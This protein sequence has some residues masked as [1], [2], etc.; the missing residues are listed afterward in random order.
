MLYEEQ[1]LKPDTRQ[2][3][4]DLG[5]LLGRDFF[6]VGGT[7]LAIQ[8]GHRLSID[9]DFFTRETFEPDA[10]LETLRDGLGSR[11]LLVTGRAQNTLNLVIDAVKVDLIRYPYTLLAQPREMEGYHLLD[12]PDIAAMKL[13]AVTNRGSK[14]D[15]FDIV[16]L[17]RDHSLEQLL[18]FYTEKFPD[19]DPFFVIRSLGFFEDADEEPDPRMLLPLS[20]QEVK[21]EIGKQL[22]KTC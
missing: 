8:I 5:R 22:R 1:A 18:E 9:L 4:G 21:R 19:H 11:N 7:A 10:L 17:L 3:L 12:I 13:A 6:L 16:I 15:F 14:K 20:W 2:L